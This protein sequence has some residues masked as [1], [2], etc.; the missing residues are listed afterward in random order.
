MINYASRV[1]N[2]DISCRVA[3]NSLS[4]V[5]AVYRA[6]ASFLVFFLF[7]DCERLTRANRKENWKALNYISFEK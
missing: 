6:N 4:R 1:H 2:S 7:V 5:N 3:R